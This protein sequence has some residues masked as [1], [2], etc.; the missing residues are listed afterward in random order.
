MGGVL[1]LG[2]QGRVLLAC[3]LFHGPLGQEDEPLVLPIGSV[4]SAQCRGCSLRIDSEL[5]LGHVAM[6]MSA[7]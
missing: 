1:F 4:T 3:T 2:S 6:E 7:I 5:V